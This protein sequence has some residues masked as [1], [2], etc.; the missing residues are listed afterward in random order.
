MRARSV[1]QAL[2]KKRNNCQEPPKAADLERTIR[3]RTT[4]AVTLP[5]SLL[6][7]HAS[8]S[9]GRDNYPLNIHHTALAVLQQVRTPAR[10]C[11]ENLTDCGLDVQDIDYS[12]AVDVA[13]RGGNGY[14]FIRSDR[15]RARKGI[16]EQVVCGRA[17]RR[18]GVD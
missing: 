12:I 18:A 14:K 5:Q 2:R 7:D 8:A 1:I 4:P 6:P 17:N 9:H 13:R 11:T 3:N 15:G 10:V 16:S